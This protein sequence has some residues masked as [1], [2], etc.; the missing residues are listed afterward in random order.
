MSSRISR[1][2]DFKCAKCGKTYDLDTVPCNDGCGG[3]IDITLDIEGLKEV[4]SWKVIEKR[5]GGV[6][7]FIDLMP[8]RSAKSHVYLG[9]GDTPLIKSRRLAELMSLNRLFLK[10]ETLNPTG[11]F[12]DR[13]VSVGVSRAVE[14]GARCVVAASSG[15]AAA[16]MSAYAASAGL[17]AVVLV[18]EAAPRAKLVHLKTL[19]ADVFRVRSSGEG[20]D[21]TTDLLEQACNRFGWTP[22]P[23]FGPFNCFQ[24][25]GTKTLGYEVA[26]EMRLDP[27]DWILFPTGSGGLMAGTMKGLLEF[28]DMGLIDDVPRP[29]VVQP[30]GCAPIV[31]AARREGHSETIERWGE[32]M[33]VAGGLADPYPWDWDAAI[34]YLKATGGTAVAVKDEMIEQY[35]TRLAKTE[36]I[37]AEP[38]GVAALPGLEMLLGDGVIDATDTVLVPITGSGFKDLETAARLAG[39]VPVIPPDVNQLAAQLNSRP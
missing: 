14:D 21:P 10:N 3:R 39:E 7:R 9:E 18:P 11:S 32:P 31:R 25:E 30:E 1:F 20:V 29:V 5:S 27:P 38:S 37:F 15:N 23:S 28:R 22:V 17:K 19:G 36:G 16:A 35:V 26:C 24:F 8:L 12:K 33:T 6:R 34:K 4:I 13:P 2:R